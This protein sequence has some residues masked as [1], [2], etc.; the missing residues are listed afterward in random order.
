MS[1]RVYLTAAVWVLGFSALGQIVMP[2]E[3]AAGSA[4]GFAPGWQREIGFFD[5]A[6]GLVALRALRADELRFR[7]SAVIAIVVLT[8]LVGTNHLVAVVSERA[9]WVHVVFT[10]VNYAAVAFGCAALF[11]DRAT[12]ST[13]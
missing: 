12:L 5:L 8:T 3:I 2:R 4:R 11:H 6:M 13:P 9:S 7:R 10:G 1:L